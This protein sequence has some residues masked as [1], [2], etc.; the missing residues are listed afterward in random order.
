MDAEDASVRWVDHSGMYVDAMTKK[1]NGN[2]PL[3]QILMRTG[4]ICTTKE[5]AILAKHRMQPSS[6]NTE[7]KT[8]M[9]PA[10]EGSEQ[11]CPP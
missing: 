5:A 6:R 3:L 10:G 4:R 11:R 1:K 9:D 2:I 7:S 8:R